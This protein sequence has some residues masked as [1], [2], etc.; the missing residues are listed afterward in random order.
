MLLSF[1][2]AFDQIMLGVLQT[3]TGLVL[4]RAVVKIRKFYGKQEHSAQMHV[5]TLTLHAFA[6]GLFLL[7]VLLITLS[8]IVYVFFPTNSFAN[9]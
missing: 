5:G 6:F 4:V 7:S 8:Y 3:I 1:F 9:D 2:V